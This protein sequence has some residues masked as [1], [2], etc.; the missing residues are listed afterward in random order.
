M[1][2]FETGIVTHKGVFLGRIGLRGVR[3][4][5]YI[6]IILVPLYDFIIRQIL[7]PRGDALLR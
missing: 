6:K 3:D 5:V 2:D 1:Q 4:A 7:P